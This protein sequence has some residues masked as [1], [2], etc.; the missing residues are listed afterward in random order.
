MR[1][2]SRGRT[3][4]A[5][6]N[7]KAAESSGRPGIYVYTLPHYRRYP[8]EPDT[9]KTLLKVGHSSTDAYLS[10]GLTGPSYGAARGPDPSPYL[11]GRCVSG[12]RAPESTSGYAMLTIRGRELCAADPSGS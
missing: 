2:P 4:A 7:S 11:P 10:R 9:G 5:V 6:E 12:C 3:T 1:A 8:V